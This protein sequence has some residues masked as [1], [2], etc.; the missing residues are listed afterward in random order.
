MDDYQNQNITELV[1]VLKKEQAATEITIRRARLGARLGTMYKKIDE[2]LERLT[3]ELR[4]GTLTV[5][6]F[7][8]SVKDIAHHF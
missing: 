7:L 3:D 2:M 6:E 5:N 1:S 8:D 4:D